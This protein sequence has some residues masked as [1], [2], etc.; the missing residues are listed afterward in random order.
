[1]INLLNSCIQTP[2]GHVVV[3]IGTIVGGRDIRGNKP[4]TSV[5]VDNVKPIFVGQ[6][7]RNFL[8]E[9]LPGFG[10]GR[11]NKLFRLVCRGCVLVI[12]MVWMNDQ[13]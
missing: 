13:L 8:Q 12:G 5:A 6:F 10:S 2:T 4:V 3:E 9:S 7:S 11:F 1:M